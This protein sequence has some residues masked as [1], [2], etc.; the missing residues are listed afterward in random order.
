VGVRRSLELVKMMM[1]IERE[2]ASPQCP[3]SGAIRGFV[4]V[5]WI[6][7]DAAFCILILHSQM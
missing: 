7:W 1:V 3:H 5:K 2:L 6:L 4:S